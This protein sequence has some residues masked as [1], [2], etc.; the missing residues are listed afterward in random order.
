MTAERVV[1]LLKK[2][3]CFGKFE[4]WTVYVLDHF[5]AEFWVHGEINSCFCSKT[6]LQMFLLDGH[7]HGFSTQISINLSKKFLRMSCLRKITVT[8]ILARVFAY[9]PSFFSQILDF[10]YRT[11]LTSIFICFEWKTSNRYHSISVLRGKNKVYH[12]CKWG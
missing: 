3:T 12:I 5:N 9:L 11:V 1:V 7:Q 2:V 6:Q 4:I 10:I 8:W